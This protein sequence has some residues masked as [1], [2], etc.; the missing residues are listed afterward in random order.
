M[1]SQDLQNMENLVR[2]KILKRSFYLRLFGEYI[3]FQNEVLENIPASIFLVTL[4]II[5]PLLL[6]P[7]E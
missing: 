4:L 7:G 6:L 2:T 5:L 1:D 3:P